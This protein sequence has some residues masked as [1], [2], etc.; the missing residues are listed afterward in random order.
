MQDLSSNVGINLKDKNY[1]IKYIV[2]DCIHI[3]TYA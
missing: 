1:R 2:L 3:Y